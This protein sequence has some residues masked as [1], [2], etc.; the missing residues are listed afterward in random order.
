V[1]QHQSASGTGASRNVEIIASS[2]SG[3]SSRYEK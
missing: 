1:T 3:R 2:Q